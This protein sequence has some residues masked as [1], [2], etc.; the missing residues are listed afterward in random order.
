MRDIIESVMAGDPTDPNEAARRSMRS[1][2]RKRF[3]ENATA[4]PAEDG[5]AV[6]LDGR[7]VRTP[8]RNVLVALSRPLVQALADE[9]QAQTEV[10]DP[11][12]MPLT[13]LANTIIDGVAPNPQPVAAEIEQYLGSDLLFYRAE[14]P[15]GLVRSQAE[16][17]DP[18]LAWA[19]E[20]L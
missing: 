15:E 17:W 14:Q 20:A 19:H 11:A 3:Y 13:R 16:H 9:W 8:A 4:E 12:K 7:P 2:V 18:V 10:I 1:A 6:R 5:F